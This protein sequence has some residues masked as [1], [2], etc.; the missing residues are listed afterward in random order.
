MWK[1]SWMNEWMSRMKCVTLSPSLRLSG[2][3]GQSM[4]DVFEWELKWGMKSKWLYR[5]NIFPCYC[6]CYIFV[7]KMTSE[8]RAPNTIGMKQNDAI[9]T[10][11]GKKTRT[12]IL[13]ASMRALNYPSSSLASI[14][15]VM[16]YSDWNCWIY[17]YI[18]NR[19]S[20]VSVVCDLLFSFA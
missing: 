6:F 2:F 13:V 3:V 15:D 4:C 1:S 9:I 19:T 12:H 11:T 16:F 5:Q 17:I 18:W 7:L 8:K 14:D 10:I 20:V